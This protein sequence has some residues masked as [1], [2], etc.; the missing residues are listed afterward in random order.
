MPI[1]RCSFCVVVMRNSPISSGNV[2]D[3]LASESFALLLMVALT[4]K[5]LKADRTTLSIEWSD[6]LVQQISWQKLRD[7]CPCATCRNK[8]DQP[9]Q[10]FNILKPEE[11][12]PVRATA[13]HPV[14][15]Y[16]YQIDF[17]D[18]HNSGI[19]SLELLRELGEG[20]SPA[21]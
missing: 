15:N 7:R 8:H 17:S 21:P 6:G 16:A 20:S 19:Y 2:T 10:L 18:G 9:P 1:A 3:S 11:A 4:P 5:S 12:A 13:M 14:G